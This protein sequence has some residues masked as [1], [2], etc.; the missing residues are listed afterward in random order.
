MKKSKSLIALVALV[1]AAIFFYP[2]SDVAGN[3]NIVVL[4]KNNTI[5]LS[6]EVN[7]ENASQVIVQA[8]DLSAG[9]FKNKTPIYLFTNTPGGSIQTGLEI[10]EALHGVG[11]PISTVSLFSASM[12]FQIAQGLGERLILS[13]GV[14]MSHR[15]SGQFSGSFGGKSPSQV[16]S[17]YG[18]WLSRMTELDKQ[19]VKRTNG[20]QTLE[21]YQNAYANE[22]WLTGAQAVEG[23][24]ADRVV[25]V[26]C[27]S[28]LDGVTTHELVFFG[29]RIQYDLDK[30]PVNTNPMNIRVSAPNEKT[31]LTVDR[32]E[33]VKSKFLE[34]YINTRRAVYP[35]YW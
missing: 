1:L 22:L 2:S 27:D 8:R 30:C 34:Q 11:R 10:I 7:G 13:N 25:T 20:K 17:R 12:G 21:S 6:G 29:L 24:Y 5:V 33:E 28:S 31:A 3:D 4:S 23:G 16:D 9:R 35:M 26:K 18:L 14:L 15:A 32:A 19:T